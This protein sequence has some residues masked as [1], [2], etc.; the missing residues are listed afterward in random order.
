MATESNERLFAEFPP[1]STE[2]WEAAINV[3][4]KG[5]DYAKKLVTKT[6]DGINIQ[7]YY[8]RSDLVQVPT[9]NAQPGQYPYI[10]GNHP[11]GNPWFV[12]QDFRVTADNITEIN[13]RALDVLNRGIDSLGF[14]LCSCCNPTQELFTSLLRGIDLNVIELNLTGGSSTLRA[15]PALLAHLKAF[16]PQQVRLSIDYSPLSNLTLRGKFDSP[17]EASLDTVVDAIEAVRGYPNFHVL[18]I[19][20]VELNSCGAS[21]SQEL[22][23]ALSQAADY[24]AALTDR[25]LSIDEL[26][27]RTRFN[28]AISANFF[29]EL[30]KFRASRLLWAKM[31][32]AHKPA[33]RESAKMYIHAETSRWNQTVYDAY[34]NLLR[35]TTEA[36][37]AVIAGVD[38]LNILPFD[39]PYQPATPF[40]ERIARNQQLLLKEESYLDKIA[41]PAAGSYYVETLTHSIAQTAWK[42]FLDTE[43]LGGYKAAF[44]DGKVQ[45]QIMAVANKRDQNFAQR[46]ETILGTNQ[47]PN[48][49]EVADPKVIAAEVVTRKAQQ[50]PADGI[51]MPL[52]PY[53]G[54]QALEA[55]RYRTDTSGKRPKVFM[56]TL[57]NLAMRRARAQFA[58]N[59]FAIAGFEVMD[60]IG[61]K[62]I[63]EGLK[64]A[65]AQNAD[66][67]V[68][69]SSDDEYATLAPEAAQQLGD[70]AIFVVAGDPACRPDLEAQGIKQ[71]IHVKSNVLETLEYYQK[72]LNILK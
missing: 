21:V 60:N 16:D 30:A 57:G 66:V 65:A 27:H 6:V 59:F 55:L 13:R 31:V 29:M 20:S 62:T 28:M 33:S 8:R 7:P 4:L 14:H 22:G 41:D 18:A 47:F 5:A 44:C 11:E 48:F 69:C 37:S 3:D 17:R 51:A 25:G 1:V 2:Q 64:A 26:A 63:E 46:R 42:L 49:N 24:L 15:L 23:Y 68:I 36:M 53:R 52:V 50:Q 12:R 38:S 32:D 43:D 9:A 35:S 45:E 34:V 54:S 61:F 71:F 10:R 39:T 67:V 58:C 19:N 40:S 70:R 72:Q 56:L